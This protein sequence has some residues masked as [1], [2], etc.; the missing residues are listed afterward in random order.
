MWAK[1]GSFYSSGTLWLL[2]CL[3][4]LISGWF[5]FGYMC[6]LKKTWFSFA[7]I[8]CDIYEPESPS[9][10]ECALKPRRAFDIYV[11]I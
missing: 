7:Y 9:D 6:F 10:I 1:L 5:I 11:K 2:V 3:C 4:W 8:L